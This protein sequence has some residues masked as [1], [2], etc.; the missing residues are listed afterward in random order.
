MITAAEIAHYGPELLAAGCDEVPTMWNGEGPF[1]IRGNP[2]R[3]VRLSD[4][5]TLAIFNRAHRAAG[6]NLETTHYN[7][8]PG[9]V[10]AGAMG[11]VFK[12]C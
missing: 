1:L 4:R 11:N 12:T 9:A 10:L 2:W 8:L 3:L 6:I 7:G 5:A